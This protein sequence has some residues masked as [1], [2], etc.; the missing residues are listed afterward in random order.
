MTLSY[1]IT[2]IMVSGTCHNCS[3]VSMQAAAAHIT[4]AAG[5][6]LSVVTGLDGNWQLHVL[7]CHHND[8]ATLLPSHFCQTCMQEVALAP[9]TDHANVKETTRHARTGASGSQLQLGPR[10]IIAPHLHA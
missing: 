5:A 10:Y 9:S 8:C 1:T 3:G 6:V 4:K 7:L 2:R